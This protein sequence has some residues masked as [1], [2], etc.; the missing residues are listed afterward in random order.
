MGCAR[1]GYVQ[2]KAGKAWI[3]VRASRTK[4]EGTPHVLKRLKRRPASS[5]PQ[6]DLA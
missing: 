6:P 2:S 5:L 1:G 3:V 4:T